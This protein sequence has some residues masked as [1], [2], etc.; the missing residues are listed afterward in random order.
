VVNNVVIY[1]NN[2]LVNNASTI[3]ILQ[4]L[5]TLL[6]EKNIILSYITNQFGN[7]AF[8]KLYLG[9]RVKVIIQ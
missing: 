7:K 1:Y 6:D 3:A 9:T 2:L 4:Q 5:K 8:L